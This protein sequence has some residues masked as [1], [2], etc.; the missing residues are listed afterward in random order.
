MAEYGVSAVIQAA[1]ACVIFSRNVEIHS[2]MP[3]LPSDPSF[4]DPMDSLESCRLCRCRWSHDTSRSPQAIFS[5]GLYFLC[6]EC[7]LRD[8]NLRIE[9][10]KGLASGEVVDAADI[11][12]KHPEALAAERRKAEGKWRQLESLSADLGKAEGRLFIHRP[13]RPTDLAARVCAD[14]G[15]RDKSLHYE[16]DGISDGEPGEKEEI[17]RQLLLR[18]DAA[19]S[20]NELALKNGCLGLLGLILLAWVT[21]IICRWL[22]GYGLAP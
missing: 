8:I 22:Q 15:L 1:L 13:I 11:K 20:R 12:R 10:L 2:E 16:F 19:V 18:R 5:I 21:W 7:Y 4:A 17:L 3:T 6:K 14:L 9:E